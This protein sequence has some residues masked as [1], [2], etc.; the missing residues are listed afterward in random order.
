MKILDAWARLCLR[1]EFLETVR[2]R[3]ANPRSEVKASLDEL[4]SE[5]YE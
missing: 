1:A 5:I 4:Q 3:L 2:Y